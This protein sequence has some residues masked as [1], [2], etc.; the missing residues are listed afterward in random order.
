[1]QVDLIAG[2]SDDV[3]GLNAFLLTV[4]IGQFEDHAACL[5]PRTC[6]LHPQ[7]KRNFAD[8]I[9]FREPARGWP[10]DLSYAVESD[11]FRQAAEPVR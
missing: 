9:V 8:N 11:S 4:A 10:Q 7:M 1:M 5:T 3:V 2:G 6:N